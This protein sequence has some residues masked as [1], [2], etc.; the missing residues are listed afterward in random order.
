M[1]AV[2]PHVQPTET[3]DVSSTS[4]VSAA[5]ASEPTDDAT[6]FAT[7]SPTA[8]PEDVT[9]NNEADG[10][11]EDDGHDSDSTLSVDSVEVNVAVDDIVRQAHKL[12][13]RVEKLER[14]EMQSQ[15]ED[16]QF[17]MV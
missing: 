3:E 9:E 16:E 1:L 5:D 7:P 6:V 4:A 8:A 2:E 10:E 13:E 14:A 11:D 17:V 15:G 12:G